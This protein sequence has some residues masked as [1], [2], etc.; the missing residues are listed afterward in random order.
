MTEK[1][2]NGPAAPAAPRPSRK[3]PP[4]L[5]PKHRLVQNW[6][7]TLDEVRQAPFPNSMCL[8]LVN[9]DVLLAALLAH[10]MALRYA[11]AETGTKEDNSFGLNQ[12]GMDNPQKW[13]S[14][15]MLVRYIVS[16]VAADGKAQERVHSGVLYLVEN[17]LWRFLP[18]HTTTWNWK[19]LT[20]TNHL[21][22][23]FYPQIVTPS[24]TILLALFPEIKHV[25]H[26]AHFLTRPYPLKFT[27]FGFAVRDLKEGHFY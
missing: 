5:A 15:S 13:G 23:P 10:Y 26:M 3:Q 14:V 4:Y 1:L 21:Y 22:N 9:I 17:V 27:G 20:V 16:T 24:P 19:R 2:D 6:S 11:G 7:C 18:G 25:E 8:Q 12:F